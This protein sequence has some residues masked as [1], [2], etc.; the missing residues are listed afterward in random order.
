M[1]FRRLGLDERNTMHRHL[2]SLMKV[3]FMNA[4]Y[5]RYGAKR[6]VGRSE[7]WLVRE[8]SREQ[9]CRKLAC[10]L[11]FVKSKILTQESSSL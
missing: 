6:F 8:A 9:R 2:Y 11:V 1:F 4:A 3:R 7:C 10:I 5:V